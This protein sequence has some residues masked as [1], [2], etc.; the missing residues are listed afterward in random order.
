MGY[1][2]DRRAADRVTYALNPLALDPRAR[3][4]IEADSEAL[5]QAADVRAFVERCRRSLASAAAESDTGAEG[6]LLE[7]ILART[8]REDLSWR[9]D[10]R[11]LGR[12]VRARFV[13]SRLL[14]VAAAVLVVHVAGLS[15]LAYQV[16]VKAREPHLN[17]DFEEPPRP[18]FVEVEAEPW[19][20]LAI[21][22]TQ[23][24][25]R[26]QGTETPA[27]GPGGR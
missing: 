14:R 21:P 26:V 22:R 2:D 18:P 7:R 11:L 13:A 17:V 16:L 3:A 24:E 27:A 10:L 5:E 20:D 19:P 25:P 8:T 6:G 12:F 1:E 23:E 4:A 9:G 15:V